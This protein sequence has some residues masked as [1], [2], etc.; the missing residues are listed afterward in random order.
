MPDLILVRDEARPYAT[1]PECHARLE[2]PLLDGERW[3]VRAPGDIANRL[4][5]EMADLEQEELRVIVLNTKNVVLKMLTA[6]RGNVST[7]VCRIAEL[8]RDAVRLNATGVILAHQ[9]PSGDPTP[10]PDDLHLAAEALAAGRLLDID[11]L[12]FIVIARHGYVS[13]RDRGVSFDR[14]V[15][16]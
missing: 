9:H 16:H 8:Y 15:R 1:C 6:Y 11:L 2:L 3:T 12:D 14:V 10:S 4:I 13:L 7:A 5:L